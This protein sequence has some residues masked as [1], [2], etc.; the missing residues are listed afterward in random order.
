MYDLKLMYLRCTITLVISQGFCPTFDFCD[1]SIPLG[2]QHPALWK[3]QKALERAQ[4]VLDDPE[5]SAINALKSVQ[6]AVESAKG[7][8]QDA[9][10]QF[11]GQLKLVESFT[12]DDEEVKDA[13]ETL[14]KA[15]KQESLSERKLQEA[16]DRCESARKQVEEVQRSLID[17]KKAEGALS[18]AEEELSAAKKELDEAVENTK[19]AQTALH[20]TLVGATRLETFE[21]ECN[22]ALATSELNEACMVYN[23]AAINHAARKL[24]NPMGACNVIV[25]P[26]HPEDASDAPI[27]PGSK[28]TVDNNNKCPTVASG[29]GAG[30]TAH[31]Q[32]RPPAAS[33]AALAAPATAALTAA[34]PAPAAPRRAYDALRTAAAPAAPRR[35][36]DALRTAAAR[37]TGAAAPTPRPPAATTSLPQRRTPNHCA[38]P[39]I[40]TCSF[41][42]LV[43]TI[44]FGVWRFAGNNAKPQHHQQEKPD[45]TQDQVIDHPQHEQNVNT[46]P[47]GI[48]QSHSNAT[49]PAPN[50]TATT[51]PPA[52]TT[53]TPPTPPTLASLLTPLAPALGG[54]MLGDLVFAAAVK[55]SLINAE[56]THAMHAFKA[57]GGVV[58]S[59]TIGHLAVL[60]ALGYTAFMMVVM[61][62]RD[63]TMLTVLACLLVH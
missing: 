51:T 63:L 29:A 8:V 46:N 16:K 4:K 21:Q 34:T 48:D 30:S 28:T 17:G 45:H 19:S 26:N 13:R 14:E 24:S 59:M 5:Y 38:D 50:T 60:P 43:G 18:K 6:A 1:G 55:L 52:T 44:G 47:P 42:A 7:P 31:P 58:G 57:L 11:E 32:P 49:T 15:C 3:A 62:D 39:I 54:V 9:M 10:R 20:D 41:G 56:N 35:A 40:T 53:T 2:V 61:S 33:V 27:T 36:Y 37:L 12:K 23:I 22:L 25:R